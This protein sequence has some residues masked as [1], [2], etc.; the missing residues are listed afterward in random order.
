MNI[1]GVKMTGIT[2]KTNEMRMIPPEKIKQLQKEIAEV[3]NRN[4]I[5]NYLNKPD[6]EIAS[7]LVLTLQSMV[8]VKIMASQ[9]NR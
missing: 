1:G 4:S 7:Y 6:Y 2:I 5:E 8:E 3:I 9:R